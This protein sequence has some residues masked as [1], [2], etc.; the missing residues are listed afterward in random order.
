MLAVEKQLRGLYHLT[1]SGYASR[2]EV[3][4]YFL[5]MIGVNSIVLP[6]TTDLYPSPAKRPYFS[7][8]SNAK[9]SAE[10]GCKIPGWKDAVVRYI[11]KYQF[12]KK[13]G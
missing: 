2:Y 10:L 12:V 9:I 5:E 3:A 1:N 6:V 4:R 8:M 13:G 11:Q 7:A